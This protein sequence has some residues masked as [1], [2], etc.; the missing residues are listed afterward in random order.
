VP[1]PLPFRP[2]GG[3]RQGSLL[4]DARSIRIAAAPHRVFSLIETIGGRT[5]WYAGAPLWR[6]RGAFDRACGGPGLRRGRRHPLTVE[7][8]DTIDFWRV[9]AVEPDARLR[10]AAE[11][12]VPGRAW[13][14]FEVRRDGDAGSE[15][16][17][18][19]TFAPAG[20]LGRAYWYA[21]WPAHDVL[22]RAM[23]HAIAA[24]AEGR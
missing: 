3:I 22:F 8:G 16:T 10:L 1:V 7:V 17:Q 21:L 13:L 14:E 9:E 5:G 23:L 18:T 2:Y 11:M 19:A 20:P 6:L 4:V 24:R 15:L 12:R